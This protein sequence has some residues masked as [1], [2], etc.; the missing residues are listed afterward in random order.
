MILKNLF[1][2]RLPKEQV[3][4]CLGLPYT[5]DTFLYC[6]RDEVKSDFIDSLELQYNSTDYEILWSYYEPTAIKINETIRFLKDMNVDVIELKEV[7]QLHKA[8]SYSTIILTAHRHRFLDS[9]E[10]AGNTINIEDVVDTI[11]K[12]YK[13]IVD[14][15]SCFS[16]SFLMDCKKKAIEATY[17]AAET[18][19]S[20]ELRLFIYK[21]VI[22]HLISH[23]QGNYLESLRLIIRR[24][25]AKSKQNK[26]IC[27][28]VFLGGA[29]PSINNIRKGSASAFAP[30]EIKRGEDMMVQIYIY[31]DKK[32]KSVICEAK[33]CDEYALER[34]HIPL[35]FDINEG[36][37][38]NVTLRVMNSCKTTQMKS[39]IWRDCVSKVCFV[40][41]LSPK[42]KKNKVFIEILLSINNAI[43]GELLFSASVVDTY[44]QERKIAKVLSNSFQKIFISYSH[45]DE[46]R[47]KFIAEAYRAQG[48]DYFFDRHYLKAGDVYPMKIQQYINSADLFILC[49]SKNAAES[50]YV[51]LERRQALA[52]AYPQVEM[53]NAT[54]TIHPISIEPRADYPED[55]S[56]IYNF[57]EV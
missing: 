23:Q 17:I 33:K 13:G 3:V 14:I 41:S 42:Y 19:S 1:I 51:T 37:Q 22:N 20:V 38:V 31:K 29:K 18:E 54:I 8:Y 35:N 49:W 25:I 28:T 30:N 7:N 53:E 10:F 44:T 5:K 11:P 9:L 16:S 40:V 48:V 21:Q 2:R 52:L 36:D 46:Q 27:D 47:V 56:E 57:E 34:S 6:C 50:D 15:S 45:M 32:H 43:L 24:I 55:M 4:W 39:F 12:S 26:Q